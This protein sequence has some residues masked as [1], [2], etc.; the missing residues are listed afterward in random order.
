MASYLLILRRN[1]ANELGLPQAEMFTRFKDW[2]LSLHNRG[3]LRGVER[4]KP[5][6]EGTTAR[7]RNGGVTVEGPYGESNEAVIG[8]YLVDA[9][10]L[11]EVQEIAKECPILLVGGSV[12]IR[13]TEYFPKP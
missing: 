6:A 8:T 13:E 1:Q 9:A 2:T 4:L 11:E 3:I 5:S 12:E 7:N 10:D